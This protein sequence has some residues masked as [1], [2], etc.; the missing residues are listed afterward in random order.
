MR[1]RRSVATA[2]IGAAVLVGSAAGG[3]G[4]TQASWT[5]DEAVAGTFTAR[6]I[7]FPTI[8][9]CLFDPG[10][11]GA[12]PSLT[13][14]W[15]F[16]PSSS[17]TIPGNVLY[18]GGSGGLLGIVNLGGGLSTSGPNGSNVYTTTY[19]NGLLA[20]ALG[21]S[22]GFGIRATE[23]ATGWTSKLSSVTASATLAG[24]APQCIINGQSP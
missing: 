6:V 13:F 9:T 2:V 18:Y 5:R 1:W 11:L 4:W 19:Q 16:D 22:Y 20:G 12:T 24:L 17:Y 7:A 3:A 21:S 8:L 23:P 14:T 15:K 10:L